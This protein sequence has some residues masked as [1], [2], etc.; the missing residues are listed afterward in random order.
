MADDYEWHPIEP[1]RDGDEGIDIE[2]MQPLYESWHSAKERIREQS[3]QGLREFTGKLVRSLSIETGILE[4]LYDLDRGTTEALVLNGFI[5]DL[6]SHSSTNIEPALL[7]DILRAQEAGIQLVMDC[8]AGERQLSKGLLHELYAI[9]TEHQHTTTAV[10]QFGKRVDIPL[11]KGAFKEHPNNPRRPDGTVHEY[12]PPVQ[13]EAEVE[14]L[15][16]WQEE[17]QEN[18][19]DPLILAGWFHHRFTQIHPYQDGNG[20]VARALTTLVLLRADLLPLVIDRDLKAEYIDALEAADHGNLGVLVDFFAVLERRA[21]LQALSIDVDA[22]VAE[23]RSITRAVIESLSTRFDRRREERDEKFRR[24]NEV[25]LKL[26]SQTRTQLE[27]HLSHLAQTVEKIADPE[28]HMTEG[29]PDWD[30]Q[31][32]FKYEVVESSRPSGKWVNFQEDHYFIKATIKADDVRLVFVVSLHHVGRELS[33]IMEATS[34][35]RLEF[36][37]EES[38]ENLA[39]NDTFFECSL[40]PFVIS[41]NSELKRVAPSYSRW[42]DAALA[43]AVKEWGDQL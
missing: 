15:L 12:C 23:D 29:G 4:R 32:W 28:I 35:G 22:H 6:V 5:E 24:V 21:I 33:G 39:K 18:G 8:V 30:N 43:I 40:E 27:E 10:D 25:A 16:Q 1:L 20:R 31:H 36:Y 9:L 11:R 7:I 13:V 17:Y 34:F 19:V 26:R 38:D 37:D 42:L 14:K 3:P 41:W 2:E